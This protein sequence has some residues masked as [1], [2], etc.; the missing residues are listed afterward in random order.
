MIDEKIFFA[1][2]MK[3]DVETLIPIMHEFIHPESII[4]SDEWGAY[5][6]VNMLYQGY[7]IQTVNY[8]KKFL[9]PITGTCANRIECKWCKLKKIPKRRYSFGNS[10]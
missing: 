4:M 9:Y 6:N 8:S 2:P 7:E 3:R 5:D 1:A 10:D